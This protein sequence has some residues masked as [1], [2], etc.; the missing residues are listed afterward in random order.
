[1]NRLFLLI[2]LAVGS[3]ACSAVRS[4]YE[5]PGYTV[6]GPNP[7]KRIGITAWAP[8]DANGLADTLAAVAT[9]LVKLRKN[10]LVYSTHAGSRAFTELCADKVE[11]VLVARTLAVNRDGEVVHLDM[12]LELY[13]CTDGALVWRADGENSVASNDA[14][15]TSLT[16]NYANSV[17]DA[18]KTFAAPAFSLLQD[19]I[20]ELPDPVLTDEDISEKIELG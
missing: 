19:L 15:L 20:A 16:S 6:Q 5:Q 11:G 8:A 3:N 10:Y 13:R 2:I 7:I 1:M 4:V 9:D 14:N 12:A 17:G 18:A